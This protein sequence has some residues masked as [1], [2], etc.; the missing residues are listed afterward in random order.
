MSRILGYILYFVFWNP[1]VNY[2]YDGDYSS[3]HLSSARN[4]IVG[5]RYFGFLV[6]LV[7]IM[8]LIFNPSLQ[9]LTGFKRVLIV[10][11]TNEVLIRVFKIDVEL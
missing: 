2:K 8:V 1:P 7:C 9:A 3:W 11:V 4:I 6:I 10:W 5:I